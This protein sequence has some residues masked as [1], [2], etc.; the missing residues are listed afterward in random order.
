MAFWLTRGNEQD[1]TAR[2]DEA[3]PGERAACA[4]TELPRGA[5]KTVSLLGTSLLLALRDI[6]TILAKCGRHGSGVGMRALY[7]IS[8][9]ATAGTMCL[10]LGSEAHP[11][12]KPAAPISVGT[13]SAERKSIEQV[14]NFVGRVEAI[15]RVEV[16]ARVKG[17]LDSVLFREGDLVEEGSPLYRIEKG[18]F[19]A[20]VGQAQG[21]LERSKAAKILTE[22]QLG[23]A[24]ELLTKAVGTVAARDQAVA[25]DRQASG[26]I[27]TDEAN[28][29]TAKINLGYTDI[30]SPITGRIGKTNITKGNVVSPESGV[31]VLIVSQDPM[32][33]MF[34]VSQREFL[35][36][37][38]AERQ[39][40]TKLIDVKLRF[41]D[42]AIYDQVGRINFVDVTVDKSTDTILV[43]ASFPNPKDIL[44][45]GQ[46]VNVDLEI[47]TPQER[48]LVPQAALIADQGGVYVF[49]VEEG[50]AQVRRLTL[51]GESGTNVVVEKGLAGGEQIVVEGLQGVRAGMPLKAT[52][53]AASPGRS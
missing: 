14:R 8:L 2:S 6:R 47:D 11:Q 31:L 13:V 25:A 15:N 37:Q 7:L 5:K 32:H 27:T 26:A 42:G 39:I 33:V 28:L 52:P 41:S 38:K 19:E 51:G 24:E 46:L 10:V 12:E 30:I 49:V 18:L 20:A 21:A 29:E 1:M 34:P 16:R 3:A 9:V 23:R 48:V 44:T 17:Y 35:H 50:K 4:S 43:R 45:D 36:L 53:L 22:V 40:D